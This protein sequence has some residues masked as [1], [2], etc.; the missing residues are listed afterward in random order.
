MLSGGGDKNLVW[1][2]GLLG[3]H[4]SRWVEMSNFLAGGRG[5]GE[6]LYVYIYIYKICDHEITQTM[7]FA[8]TGFQH[9]CINS[10]LPNFIEL[11]I[12]TSG[13]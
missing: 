2:G 5:G 3:V 11:L 1:V 9:F 4:F 12:V 8:E 6:T 7:Q 10:N 13:L